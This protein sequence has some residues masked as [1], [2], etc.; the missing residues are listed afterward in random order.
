MAPKVWIDTESRG[1]R[2]RHRSCV[3]AAVQSFV[4]V[5]DL[6]VPEADRAAVIAG[7]GDRLGAVDSWRGFRR[8][9]LIAR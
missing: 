9:Q 3:S 7:F 5:R 2:P 4:A 8:Y 1:K 6:T